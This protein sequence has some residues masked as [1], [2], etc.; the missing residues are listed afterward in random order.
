MYHVNNPKFS[1]WMVKSVFIPIALL[2]TSNVCMGQVQVPLNNLD[3]FNNPGKSWSVAGG[4][5]AALEGST[6]SSSRGEGVLV[7]NPTKKNPGKDLYSKNEYGDMDLELEYMMAPG[8]NS[9]IY[10]QGRYEIQL[11]DSWGV[12]NPR[13]GDNGGVY[14]RWDDT[15]PEGQ[16][17]YQGYAPRQNVSRAPGLWQQL[18]VSFKAPRFDESGKKIENARIIQM[19]LNGVVI[20]ENLELFGPTRGG[21]GNNE[22]AEGPLRIQGDHGAVAFRNI[23]ITSFDTP[24]P[25]LTSL[26]YAIYEGRFDQQP[27]FNSLSAESEGTTDIL[28]SRVGPKPQQFLIKYNGTL[29]IKEAGEYSFNLN[30]P[31]GQGNVI[32]NGQEALAFGQGY[33]VGK[34][35]LPSG[36][37][38]LELVYS[39]YMDW[40]EPGLGLAIAGPG[41]REFQV[42]NSNSVQRNEADPILV[43]PK[44]KP[45]LRSFMDVPGYGRVTHAV[46]VGSE[47]KVHFTYDLDHGSLFQVWRGEFL[48]ATPMWNNRGDGSSRP[49]GSIVRLGH[50][51][52][53][54]SSLSSADQAWPADTVGTAFKTLGYKIH[55]N[56]DISFMYRAH[57]A[58]I[59][60][61][62]VILE[63]G[64]GVKRQL[65][66]ENGP[67]DAYY[68]L[69]QGENIKEVGA[70]TYLVEDKAYYL[71]LQEGSAKAIIRNVSGQQELIV[72]VK[73]S[74][75]YTLL[76]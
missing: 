17:G 18:A 27:D 46:S 39:K 73:E 9:G 14:E 71:K 20:H 41:L 58:T 11:L 30:V 36:D 68:L 56:N 63:N 2:L 50:P 40:V 21:M 5:S 34:V 22:K 76:F 1:Q 4:V 16:K 69:A 37:V 23:N 57:G 25:E 3:F 74:L 13:S 19:T 8:S 43:D 72:P 15:K 65:K 38:P 47:A 52:V 53:P 60:D 62:V 48:N 59:A 12:A 44:E 75:V 66:I 45:L 49:L 29:N 55:A 31:G 32:V 28:T 7:N 64:Q 51:V 54:I 33:R 10:L 26:S 42:T 6:L 70:G 67:A 24:R 61:E 35:E